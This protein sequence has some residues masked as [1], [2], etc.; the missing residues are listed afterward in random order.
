MANPVPFTIIQSDP[1]YVNGD[2][3]TKRVLFKAWYQ[4]NKE[5]IG[6]DEELNKNLLAAADEIRER[7]DLG[8]T[9]WE[10]AGDVGISAGLGLGGAVAGLVTAG[11]PGAV[12]GGGAGGLAG[13]DIVQR[14]ELARG[15]KFDYSVARTL[16]EGAANLIPGAT[17][18]GR[19][20][21]PVVRA[22]GKDALRLGAA[23]GAGSTAEQIETRGEVDPLRVATD[24][25]AMGLGAG[26]LRGG[27]EAVAKPLS[28]AQ[29]RKMSAQQLSKIEEG[30]SKRFE[31][32][33]VE[34]F[35]ERAAGEFTAEELARLGEYKG[36]VLEQ[37]AA[38]QAA[39]EQALMDEDELA[40]FIRMVQAEEPRLARGFTAEEQTA[41]LREVPTLG[42][43]ELANVEGPL[44]IAKRTRPALLS[45]QA[46]EEANQP[47]TAEEAAAILM[48]DD[49]IEATLSL[50][51][52]LPI[53]AATDT[54]AFNARVL[55]ELNGFQTKGIPINAQTRQAAAAIARAET[56]A[57]RGLL[58][59]GVNEMFGQPKAPAPTVKQRKR[60]T[61]FA[62]LEPITEQPLAPPETVVPPVQSLASQADNA[63]GAGSLDNVNA[64]ANE[65]SGVA[66]VAKQ[67]PLGEQALEAESA[68]LY[69]VTDPDGSIFV[70]DGQGNIV[71][72]FVSKADA[73]DYIAS[74]AGD[75]APVIDE[76]TIGQTVLLGTDEVV[77]PAIEEPAG[78][79]RTGP[80]RMVIGI[81]GEGKAEIPN[82][83]GWARGRQE[84]RL[85]AIEKE[86]DNLANETV[87]AGESRRV[88]LRRE[89]LLAENN[90]ARDA[91]HLERLK[92]Q[93]DMGNETATAAL[94]RY[95]EELA[96]GVKTA[97]QV[98]REA[99][100]S[101]GGKVKLARGVSGGE[102]DAL[103]E[104][105]MPK[106]WVARKN[107]DGRSFDG[108]RER[109][110]EA[111]EEYGYPALETE[112]DV[113]NA[114]ENAISGGMGTRIE[115]KRVEMELPAANRGKVKSG[116][117]AASTGKDAA[118]PV[119]VTPSI[120]DDSV[121]P[122]VKRSE[123]FDITGD[124]DVKIG[125]KNYKMFRDP[126]T[127]SWYR[128]DREGGGGADGYLGE[129][130]KE[131]LDRLASDAGAQAKSPRA[132]ATAAPEFK[133][134][135]GESKVVDENG[136]P[137]VVY[138]GTNETFT[139]F[140]K[141]KTAGLFFTDDP[142]M[143]KVYGDKL[144]EA[145]LS[146]QNP[147]EVEMDALDFGWT[148]VEQDIADAAKADGHDGL[149]LNN[150][151]DYMFVAFE[152]T[153]VKSAIGNRGTFDPENPSMLGI[154]GNPTL[155]SAGEPIIGA[156]AG[157]GL[158]QQEEGESDEAYQER[159]M[160][161]AL[162]GMGVMSL[163]A[164][165]V[166]RLASKLGVDAS[167]GQLSRMGAVASTPAAK[168]PTRAE[169]M[170]QVVKLNE[171]IAAQTK[172]T[173]YEGMSGP[174]V[175]AVQAGPSNGFDPAK[176]AAE[177][178][179]MNAEQRKGAEKTLNES[180]DD[181]V[182]YF[183][184]K[185]VTFN[186]AVN[187]MADLAER[188]TGK[189]LPAV[190]DPRI[191]TPTRGMNNQTQ[192]T[193]FIK[194]SGLADFVTTTL[195]AAAKAAGM[196]KQV[197]RSQLDKYLISKQALTR[198]AM[199]AT[200]EEVGGGISK[201]VAAD[202]VASLA[203]V[204]ES[205]AKFVNG[206]YRQLLEQSVSDSLVS[207]DLADWL[208]KVYPDYVPFSRIFDSDEIASGLTSAIRSGKSTASISGQTLVNKFLGSERGIESPLEELF[209]RA[210][211]TFEQGGRNATA[212]S[213]VNL[214]SSQW[215]GDSTGIKQLFRSAPDGS[216]LR[217]TG[218]FEE[219]KGG[220]YRML[221]SQGKGAL[222]EF[223]KPVI[224]DRSY[225]EK[226]DQGNWVGNG[227]VIKD[228][229][230]SEKAKHK[231]SFLHEGEKL[232]AGVPK[233]FEE[234]AKGL[235]VPAMGLFAKIMNLPVR[236]G[237][238]GFTSLN[239]TFALRQI[240]R[241]MA[242]I[243]VN[244]KDF[245]DIPVLLK[246]YG[247]GIKNA[248]SSRIPELAKMTGQPVDGELVKR[249]EQ[250]AGRFNFT[251]QFRS[252]GESKVTVSRL[253]GDIPVSERP[254][255]AL[256]RIE[257]VISAFE[258]MG[259][260]SVFKTEIDRLAGP[261][262]EQGL[263]KRS[264]Q[265]VLEGDEATLD[266]IFLKAA[267]ESQERSANYLNKG[268]WGRALNGVFL[269]LNAGIQGTRANVKAFKQ[270][271]AAYALKAMVAGG[272][273]LATA[274]AYNL[275][276]PERA[277]AYMDLTED[278][279]NRNLIVLHPMGLKDEE[280]NY[281]AIKLPLPAGISGLAQSPRRVVEDMYG[282][283]MAEGKP[284]M[285]TAALSDIFGFVTP[286]EPDANKLMSFATPQA[287]RPL[288]ESSDTVNRNF[289]SG[290][291]VVPRY[292][293]KLPPADQYRATTPLVAR[294]I[295][296]ALNISPIKIEYLTKNYTGVLGST[297]MWAADQA[298]SAA[299]GETSRTRSLSE[300]V[301]RAFS[302]SRGGEQ[303]N[304]FYAE[305][306]RSA[307]I[308]EGI[309]SAMG[310]GDE[311]RAREL[312]RDNTVEL[313]NY[314][315]LNSINQK[316]TQLY[317]D[318]R[319]LEYLVDKRPD[320]KDD[321]QLGRQQLAELARLGNEMVK[322]NQ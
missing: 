169:L 151:Y 4:V 253:M 38:Q 275:A 179:A 322:Q 178:D 95:E 196:T 166:R 139:S 315:V 29:R 82:S 42:D 144:V 24:A 105:G 94:D 118:A 163:G 171:E 99:M 152:P 297:A 104:S 229:E 286:F 290:Q 298:I 266:N 181:T 234:A 18:V 37:G 261:A 167:A 222:D 91:L 76:P 296:A 217:A 226:T 201:Q 103:L 269:Y 221:D 46:F 121:T 309:K 7:E 27:F 213:W 45:A 282:F 106:R 138:H 199:G 162:L 116:K 33:G 108:I 165:G 170:A 210:Y 128:T 175:A 25:A 265:G 188:V 183:E 122:V 134:W 112:S 28:R 149:I 130:Q 197:F 295:G 87:P 21:M 205:H 79:I 30:L 89:K 191:I 318:I 114:I 1:R 254:M 304:R 211:A 34:N 140:S 279:R 243:I 172:G 23:G 248:F 93:S 5:N 97:A 204:M 245:R 51:D 218:I 70:Q 235:N 200:E 307:A 71:D 212:R 131:A 276:T 135:F 56:S 3:D 13:A 16:A 26:V 168:K 198:Y 60:L 136:E 289:F 50:E 306:E 240:P 67:A 311:E 312:V 190:M 44:E 58:R 260:L 263:V 187:R 214:G 8:S 98:I 160:Q 78:V 17:V 115:P 10:I 207:R 54:A 100:D 57:E 83:A 192:A 113:I 185:L 74:L 273:A 133:K 283:S 255:Q 68:G 65:I 174:V 209:G 40:S 247:T 101:D 156:V 288:L 251:E 301:V 291:Q 189:K 125:G 249:W 15:D 119:E 143:A 157:F 69:V 43:I 202:F 280:G 153:Q 63:M 293:Q 216:P 173:P 256:R 262:I 66:P 259:R 313:R 177:I 238:A 49:N 150:G 75:G 310:K 31:K 241:D 36:V 225:V 155:P 250:Y 195:P 258:D 285:F 294:E 230:A 299:T 39:R 233:E 182:R 252:P 126:E 271:P 20:V 2:L 239:P 80:Q 308:Y 316:M 154:I 137:L 11:P 176:K 236:V 132:T 48:P 264:A 9:G 274:T 224:V 145:Y 278:E 203:P 206:I 227:K 267:Y 35:R 47:K 41:G 6:E 268:E 193:G 120:V 77:P 88:R 81:E 142:E 73:E 22:A 84:K 287:V 232:E 52:A 14:R 223:G 270:A 161:N 184:R 62:D 208:V 96:A 244:T 305:Y 219:V 321:I 257:D 302:T 320:L 180:V 231:I 102:I 53:P 141:G 284:E 117:S 90:A 281:L 72:E 237:R 32:E 146:L 61:S 164:A 246:N 277:K 86:L 64:A 242:Q 314:Q 110:S 186:E 228:K 220:G 300:D 292:L 158:T 107:E 59:Q 148:N 127:R 129:S 55:E 159:R 111:L 124:Y 319:T 123:D 194:E 109:L 19:G 303:L 12:V 215:L 147:K 85:R 317:S 92:I 272:A